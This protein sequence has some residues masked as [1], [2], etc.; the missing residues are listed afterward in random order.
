MNVNTTHVK[1]DMEEVFN[2]PTDY[3]SC[4]LL[5]ST[6]WF[7]EQ[8]LYVY[9]TVLHVSEVFLVNVLISSCH[10]ISEIC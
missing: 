8:A 1:C 5:I 4:P 9:M 7:A 2:I 10:S 6:V 3:K